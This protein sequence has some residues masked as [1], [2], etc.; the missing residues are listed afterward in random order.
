MSVM[1][2]LDLKLKEAENQLQVMM[3]NQS[4]TQLKT[5]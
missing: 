5:K 2:D 1:N 4:V 3:S